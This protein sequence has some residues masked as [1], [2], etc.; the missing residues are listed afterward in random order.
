MIHFPNFNK[1]IDIPFV[2]SAPALAGPARP[3]EPTSETYTTAS[4]STSTTSG[5]A[6]TVVTDFPPSQQSNGGGGM[7]LENRI[8]LG[9]GLGLGIPTF[10]V[11]TIALCLELI[12]YRQRRHHP[13]RALRFDSLSRS[14]YDS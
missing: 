11:G 13:P 2:A 10:I 8:G 5:T 1:L 7:S 3:P 12:K 6:T 4:A 14:T 9:V